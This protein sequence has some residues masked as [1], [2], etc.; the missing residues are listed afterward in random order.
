MSAGSNFITEKIDRDLENNKH[1]GRVVTRFPPE[2]NGFLHIGHAKSICLNFGLAKQY[3]GKCNLRFDD[4]NPSTEDASYVA[5]ITEDIRWLGMEVGERRFFAS[6]YFDKLYEYAVQLIESQVAYV[7]G[8]SSQEIRDSRGDFNTPGK[9]SPYRERS[10]KENLELFEKMAAGKFKEGECVL[11]AKID[12]TSSNMNLRDPIMYRIRHADHHRT[13]DKWCIYPM[14]DWAHGLEDAIEGIT[15]SI[16]TLEFENHRPLYDWFLKALGLENPPQQTE[17]ARLNL[18]YTVMSKRKLLQL[19][20]G[21]FVSGWNDPRMP[22]ISG[23]RRRGYTPESI[24]K[25]CGRIGVAK[26]DNMVDVALLEHAVRDDLNDRSPRVM[27]VLNPLKVIIDNYPEDAEEFFDAPLHPEDE[28]FGSRRVPFCRELYIESDDFREDPPKK[29]FRLSPGGEIRL[30][31]ACLIKCVS[32]VK[33]ETGKVT[34]LHCTWDPDSRGGTSPDGRKVR[35]TSH[36]VSARHAISCE[37]RNY[38]RLFNVPNPL[39]DK[40]IDFKEH[41]NPNSLEVLSGCMLE[42]SLAEATPEDR[43]QFERL[44]YFCVDSEDS[45][46]EKLVFNRTCSLRDS[47]AKVEKALAREAAAAAKHKKKQPKA[48]E[49]DKAND[50]EI[51]IE[52]FAKLDLRVAEILE[53]SLVEGADKLLRFKVGLGDGVTRQIFSGIRSAYPDPEKLVGKRVIVV[54]NL[55]PR[56]MKFGVSEGMVLTGGNDDASLVVA[57]FADKVIPGDK[58]S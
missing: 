38:D 28:S 19:V 44:G 15:H 4:T 48:K 27:A 20:E 22:T 56:K 40:N 21:G 18:S 24:Q 43:Y 5:S 46:P 57:S 30:R 54:A 2:P 26:R 16:C 35:G 29:W 3:G 1:D 31:Y 45:K 52:D 13:S 6:D 8:Q 14:Y 41:L 10:V 25:F 11:R 23:L 36:W 58:V 17:F 51:L 49:K 42:P 33:D 55:K 47:W 53:A 7:D 34:E 39:A 37:V 12:M 9:D 32:V 50:G